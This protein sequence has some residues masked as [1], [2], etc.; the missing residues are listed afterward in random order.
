MEAASISN[1]SNVNFSSNAGLAGQANAYTRTSLALDAGDEGATLQA[2][3]D[4]GA[5]LSPVEQGTLA[6]IM[7]RA[8]GPPAHGPAANDPAPADKAANDDVKTV[9]DFN[10]TGA[11]AQ[12]LKDLKEALA[13]LQQTDAKG[14]PVSETA[15]ELLDDLSD[16]ATIHIVH[17]GGDQY[18]PS[19]GVIDW[20]P[21]SGLTVTGGAGTQSAALGLIHEVDHEVN[22]LANPQ[23]TGDGY[24]NTEEQRVIQGSETTIAHDLHEP[25]RTDHYGSLEVMKS[26]TDHTEVAPPDPSVISKIVDRVKDFFDSIF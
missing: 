21:R 2:R 16:G 8:G 17:D 5:T 4:A 24:D 18:D 19:T 9:E 20:D 13:Y 22:G 23:P 11:S 6:R 25:T 10:V 12:D 14:N 1:R 26:S 3:L 7:D 15:T